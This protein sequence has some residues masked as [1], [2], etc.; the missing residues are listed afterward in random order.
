[1]PM[2]ILHLNN[3]KTW[4]GGERQTFLL[5]E[6]LEQTGISGCIACRPGGLLWQHAS[7]HGQ[8]VVPLAGN[9]VQAAAQLL[10][11]AR[12]FDLVHCH[13]AR[14]HS[15]AA[16]LG[17]LL[18][19]PMIVTRRVDFEP[20]HTAFNRYKYGRAAKVACVSNFIHHQLA[21]W[22]VPQGKL[23]TI[24]SA[25]P[26]LNEAG[27]DSAA[28]RAELGLP[29]DRPVVGNIAALVGHKDHATLLRAARRVADRRPEALFVIIGEGVLR[30]PLLRQQRELG[31]EKVVQFRG[32]V[33][34]AQR[35][36]KA[37]DV[38]AMSSCMEGLGG[39][40]LDAFRLGVPVAS[41]A[42]GGLPEMV[43]DGETGLL[44]PVSNDEA[45]AQ[46]ILRLLNE[47]D[48][49]ARITA[50]ARALLEREYSV[51]HMAEQYL[52]TYHNVLAPSL[53]RAAVDKAPI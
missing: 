20:P 12:E 38:F 48:L 19:R 1:M 49:V 17:P 33:P 43:R 35:F 32:F 16:A 7:G 47:R 41:T 29:A 21:H 25:I 26:T 46:A 24:K 39:I 31:L 3:E 18:R 45:L 14:T 4:R 30:E 9:S 10:R 5:A 6:R 28:L 13:T 51:S 2:R 8:P 40:V 52:G 27:A 11:L 53:S 23:I 34:Q 36:V 44:A 22:G 50:N 15:I 42:A 37:F